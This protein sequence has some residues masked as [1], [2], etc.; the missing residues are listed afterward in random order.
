MLWNDTS[1]I[2][3]KVMFKPGRR[4]GFKNLYRGIGF[5]NLISE[6]CALCEM[7]NVVISYDITHNNLESASHSWKLYVSS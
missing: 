5:M 4:L 1:C 7:C 2:V 3:H 6:T